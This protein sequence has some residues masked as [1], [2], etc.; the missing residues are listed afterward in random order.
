MVIG[1]KYGKEKWNSSMFN[2]RRCNRGR[3]R[4]CPIFSSQGRFIFRVVT[5]TVDTSFLALQIES[6]ILSSTFSE[7]ARVE[8]RNENVLKF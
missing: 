6:S 2:D 7:P 3:Q 4:V 8:F 1:R 5:I